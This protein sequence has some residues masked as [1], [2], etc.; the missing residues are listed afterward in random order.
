MGED[1]R[2]PSLPRRV[3]GAN[4]APTPRRRW[5]RQELPAALAQALKAA[6]DDPLDGSAVAAAGDRPQAKSPAA[7]AAIG[8]GPAAHGAAAAAASGEGPA[9]TGPP[10]RAASAA[11]ERPPPTTPASPSAAG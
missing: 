11:R 6:D 3:P 9:A 8:A 5:T 1:S 2:G 4:N 10:P 7:E